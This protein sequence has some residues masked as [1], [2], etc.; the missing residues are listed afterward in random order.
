MRVFWMNTKIF[1]T[2]L[3]NIVNY[4]RGEQLGRNSIQHLTQQNFYNA[5]CEPNRLLETMHCNST[6]QTYAVKVVQQFLGRFDGYVS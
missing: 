4:T 1:S 2:S 6:S 3:K 5:K